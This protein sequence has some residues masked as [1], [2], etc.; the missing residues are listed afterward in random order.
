MQSLLENQ[1]IRI[2][3]DP[4]RG[5]LCVRRTN[6]RFD[7]AEVEMEQWVASVTRALEGLNPEWLTL[8]V[9]L[10]EGQLRNDPS[11]EK[12]MVNLRREPFRG[13]QRMA[14]LVRTAVGELQLA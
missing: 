7:L 1:F 11:F 9:D 10:R 5:L 6:A 12:V 13:F 14:I 2:T 8:L 4:T 3:L